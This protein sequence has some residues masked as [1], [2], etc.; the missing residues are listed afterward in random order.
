ML[1][2]TPMICGVGSPGPYSGAIFDCRATGEGMI[3]D[4]PFSLIADTLLLP[5]DIWIVCSS[6]CPDRVLPVEEDLP[7][8][9]DPPGSLSRSPKTP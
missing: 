4:L 8:D 6:D 1:T 3:L 2:H 9:P 5:Y 7:V